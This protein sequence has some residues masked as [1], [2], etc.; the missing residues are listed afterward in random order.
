MC[1]FFLYFVGFLNF[2]T[3]RQTSFATL[4]IKPLVPTRVGGTKWVGHHLRAVKQHIDG[5]PAILQH[6]QQVSLLGYFFFV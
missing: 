6:M 2:K 5:Y 4:G 1:V 3:N